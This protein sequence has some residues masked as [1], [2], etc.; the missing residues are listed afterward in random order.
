[1]DALVVATLSQAT[2]WANAH[3]AMKSMTTIYGSPFAYQKVLDGGEEQLIAALRPGGMQNRK[4][5]MLLQILNDV[6]TRQGKW[7]LNHPFTCSNEDAVKELMSY[8]G[9]SPKS[10]FCILS[11]CL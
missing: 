5:R 7:D 2:S 9:V 1:M 11:I 6:R 8:K 4:A 3:R 10:A